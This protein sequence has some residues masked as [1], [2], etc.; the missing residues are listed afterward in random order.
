[1]QV[2]PA[3]LEGAF[4]PRWILFAVV[5]VAFAIFLSNFFSARQP[6]LPEDCLAAEAALEARDYDGAIDGYLACLDT[7]DLPDAVLAQIYY[8]LGIAY[9]AKGDHYQA[10]EDYGEAINL[11]PN[12]AWTYN[13]RCWSY[14]LLRRG[15]EALADCNEALRL[16]PNEPAILDSRALAYWVSDEQDK[17]RQDLERAREL[18]PAMPT[19]QDRFAEFESLF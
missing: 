18:D 9:S 8:G 12:F 4:V 15:E 7:E 16:A 3:R 14:A 19:W 10:V 6:S 5:A 17:A 1:M 11:A 2:S 13:N